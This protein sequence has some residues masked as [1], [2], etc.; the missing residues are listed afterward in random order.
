MYSGSEKMKTGLMDAIMTVWNKA[1]SSEGT[2]NLIMWADR[3]VCV[4][5]FPSIWVL[6]AAVKKAGSSDNIRYGVVGLLDLVLYQG[7][8]P[9]ELSVRQ[10]SGR[11]LPANKGR[12]DTI[13]GRRELAKSLADY[14]KAHGLSEALHAKIM[15]W[16]VG[17][18]V[19][20]TDMGFA[21]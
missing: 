15:E 19:Y 8:S 5:V 7:V 2:R 17:I 1:T 3:H 20:R 9:G 18:D 12:L 13:L 10:I 16:H 21:P 14:I 11:G 6:E 4:E